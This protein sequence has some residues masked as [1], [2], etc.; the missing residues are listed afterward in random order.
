MRNSGKVLVA[1]PEET[2]TGGRITLELIIRKQGGKVWTGC[3]WLRIGT[4]SRLL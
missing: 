2:S 1:E 3:I 4:S